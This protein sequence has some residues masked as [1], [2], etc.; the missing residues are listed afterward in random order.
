VV[1]A[2]AR[3][4]IEQGTEESFAH[5]R[6][7]LERALK[8]AQRYT[9]ILALVFMFPRNGIRHATAGDCPFVTVSRQDKGQIFRLPLEA[10]KF[11]AAS[12]E[13]AVSITTYLPEENRCYERTIAVIDGET[14]KESFERASKT[15]FEVPGADLRGDG[16]SSIEVD[17]HFADRLW[18]LGVRLVL[19]MASGERLVEYGRRLKLVK[20][21][22][23]S[24][25]SKEFWSPNFLGRVYRPVAEGSGSGESE[26]QQIPSRSAYSWPV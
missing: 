9:G 20:G 19:I 2:S 8:R 25:G 24:E 14:I 12:A 4:V 21:K 10:A 15:L 5:E 22:K 6:E 1:L 26:S 13:K 18:L 23:P 17:A 11:E 3:Q 7:I 16:G